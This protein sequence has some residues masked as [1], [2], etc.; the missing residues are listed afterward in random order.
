[1]VKVIVEVIRVNKDKNIKWRCRPKNK[2][3]I[4]TYYLKLFLTLSRTIK[5]FDQIYL[6]YLMT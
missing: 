6:I 1:M 2:L 4:L 3:I 5:L